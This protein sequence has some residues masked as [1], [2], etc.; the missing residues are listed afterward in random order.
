MQ[1]SL[2]EEPKQIVISVVLK[3]GQEPVW[4]G[5]S[6]SKLALQEA[7]IFENFLEKRDTHLNLN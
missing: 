3:H 1:T 2:V 6:L 4:L 7:I 5:E